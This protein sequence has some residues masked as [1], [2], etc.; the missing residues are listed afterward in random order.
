MIEIKKNEDINEI[1]QLCKISGI[2]FNDT[3]NAATMM[4][5]EERLGFSIFDIVD[6]KAILKNLEPTDDYALADGMLRSTIHIALQ[7]NCNSVFY[8]CDNLE[9]LFDRLG[10]IL[11]KNLKQLNTD[12]LFQSCCDCK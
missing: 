1:K 4:D 3:T 11:D 12:K 6:N 2:E 10:F 9:I 5:R 8:S 7:N